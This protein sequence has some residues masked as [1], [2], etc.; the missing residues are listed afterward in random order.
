MS[1]N[2]I[3][4]LETL[5]TPSYPDSK[6]KFKAFYNIDNIYRDLGF[7]IFNLTSNLILTNY[8]KKRD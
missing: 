4:D 3:K 8:Y 5:F 1:P 2:L 7:N 6:A